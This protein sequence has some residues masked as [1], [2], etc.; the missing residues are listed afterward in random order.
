[1]KNISN[2]KCS[3]PEPKVPLFELIPEVLIDSAVIAFVSY[4]IS[5]S[6]AKIFAKKH[7]YMVD[8]NQELLAQVCLANQYSAIFLEIYEMF[9]LVIIL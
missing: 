7:K 5:I 3:L 2:I 9:K 6:M 8:A 4:A 1:M